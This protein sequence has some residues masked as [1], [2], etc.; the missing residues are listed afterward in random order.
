[1]NGEQQFD[2]RNPANDARLIL[3]HDTRTCPLSELTFSEAKKYRI[4]D[5]LSTDEDARKSKISLYADGKLRQA[6]SIDAEHYK[7]SAYQIR[8]LHMRHGNA[9]VSDNFYE[10]F[11]KI[12]SAYSAII[13]SDNDES[14]T[15]VS[16]PGKCTLSQCV[17]ARSRPAIQ[18]Y[19]TPKSHSDINDISQ[20]LGISMSDFI[21]ICM[22]E[23]IL[24]SDASLP[25]RLK[26]H[27]NNL[28]D[29]FRKKV[30][31]RL[32]EL[33]RVQGELL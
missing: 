19:I 11:G 23:S 12:K 8:Y 32:K 28:L 21:V 6:I 33:V 4:A 10:D 5:L 22:W 25:E 17:D 29:E 2:W 3:G 30:T 9:I 18:I 7:E 20:R 24:T 15:D 14:A 1:V 13:H 31:K 16:N 27:G 26:D